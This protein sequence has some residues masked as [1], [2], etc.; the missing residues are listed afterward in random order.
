MT[1]NIEELY[2]KGDSH[3]GESIYCID[4]ECTQ[5]YT[6][7]VIEIFQ[8]KL[9]WEFQTIDGKQNGLEKI[10]EDGR[11][12]QVDEY[13]DNLQ[14]GVSK[15]YDKDGNVTSVSIVLNNLYIKTIELKG[16]QIINIDTDKKYENVSEVYRHIH[17]LVN[18]SN[19]DLINYQFKE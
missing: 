8:G 18:L 12:I 3:T 6:G 5:P 15:E 10:Y 13:K 11:L 4:K 1:K 2:T 14:F 16:N 7:W 19:E 17:K 9:S